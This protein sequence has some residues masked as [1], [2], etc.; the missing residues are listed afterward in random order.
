M[1][2]RIPNV[3]R[4]KA[5]KIY[6]NDVEYIGELDGFEVYREQSDEQDTPEPTGLPALILWDGK[7]AKIVDGIESLDLLSR[8]E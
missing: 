7:Q 1:S 3:V 5:E 4:E 6:C 2:K 8:F